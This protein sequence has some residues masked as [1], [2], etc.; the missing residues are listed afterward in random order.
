[1]P[2]WHTMMWFSF[3]SIAYQLTLALSAWVTCFCSG[4]PAAPGTRTVFLST[5]VVPGV[6][7]ASLDLSS[8]FTHRSHVNNSGQVLLS[9]LLTGP[10]INSTND[11]AVFFDDGQGSQTILAR[12]GQASP[13]YDGAVISSLRDSCCSLMGAA[14]NNSGESVIAASIQH[15]MTGEPLGDVLYR[16]E[17]GG[18]MQPFVRTGDPLSGH[19]DLVFSQVRRR[20][21]SD[22]IALSDS[23]RIAFVG[24]AQS[25]STGAS[26][27]AILTYDLNKGLVQV[28]GE[29]DLAPTD[30][31]TTF[32]QLS[33]VDI[34]ADGNILFRGQLQGSGVSSTNDSGFWGIHDGKISLV[35]RKGTPLPNSTERSFSGFNAVSAA[36]GNSLNDHNQVALMGFTGGGPTAVLFGDLVAGVNIITLPGVSQLSSSIHDL[37]NRGEVLFGSN[38]SVVLLGP[39]GSFDVIAHT[40]NHGRLTDSGKAVYSLSDGGLG[41]GAYD[42][43]YGSLIIVGNELE[44]QSGTSSVTKRLVSVRLEDV[45]EAGHVLFSATFDDGVSGLFLSNVLV[46]PEPATVLM[47][48]EVLVLC[49]QFSR[50]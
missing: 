24:V 2:N 4:A 45:S 15:A 41:I 33:D 5:D 49:V 40:I 39:E 11:Y 42:P 30:M 13:G 22:D 6:S 21:V 46:V 12:E 19:P 29:G 28:I 16:S 1:M 32:S 10:T 25:V 36:T 34:N 50:R 43:R 35:A 37:N 31:M 48:L 8:V 27:D 44:V 14:L 20:F 3:R 23:G 17:H 26:H 18:T 7:D 38:R 9:A 47:M